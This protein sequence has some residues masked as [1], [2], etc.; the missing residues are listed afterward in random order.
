MLFSSIL[1]NKKGGATLT[2]VVIILLLLGVL[3]FT[4][5]KLSRSGMLI[6]TS[7]EK[8]EQAFNVAESGLQFFVNTYITTYNDIITYLFYD[9]ANLNSLP[10]PRFADF[11]A[12]LNYSG[13]IG[14]LY[15]NYYSHFPELKGSYIIDEGSPTSTSDDVI[16]EY[17]VRVLDNDIFMTEDGDT[18]MNQLEDED[19]DP[20][21]NAVI[22]NMKID[23]DKNFFI[24]AR[25]IVRQGN[26]ILGSKLITIRICAIEQSTGTQKGGSAANVN[27]GKR[28]CIQPN[29]VQSP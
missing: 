28:F 11:D 3:G 23:R 14:S 12:L 21:N 8:N 4:L 10:D 16:G 20:Y 15:N 26:R 7:Y 2:G 22:A 1:N 27:I 19:G 18:L 17:Y 5:L 29:Y 13:E 6:A 25:G 24:Q 9:P